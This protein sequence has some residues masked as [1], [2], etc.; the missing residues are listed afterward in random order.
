MDHPANQEYSFLGS[1]GQFVCT[2]LILSGMGVPIESQ[3]YFVDIVR[4]Q[5]DD[6][7]ILQPTNLP[8][9]NRGHQEHLDFPHPAVVHLYY[10]RCSEYGCFACKSVPISTQKEPTDR[11]IFK[12]LR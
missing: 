7:I 1:L 11:Q 5:K 8:T 9:T 12:L 10:T 3:I 6:P 2:V 4:E